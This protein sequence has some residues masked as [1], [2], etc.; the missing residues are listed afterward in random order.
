VFKIFPGH[1]FNVV[2]ELTMRPEISKGPPLGWR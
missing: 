1:G 2:P